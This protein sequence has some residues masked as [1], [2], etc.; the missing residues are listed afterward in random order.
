VVAFVTTN[1]VIATMFL[2]WHYVIDVVAGLLLAAVAVTTA[3]AIT[4]WELARRAE[5]G[6]TNNWPLFSLKN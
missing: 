2:R 4:R 6:L 5:L 3:A 1:I